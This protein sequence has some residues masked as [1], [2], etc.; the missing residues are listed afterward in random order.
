MFLT[1]AKSSKDET[2]FPTYYDAKKARISQE[3]YVN[4]FPF[5]LPANQCQLSGPGGQIGWHWL[6]GNSKAQ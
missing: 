3:T 4:V 6:D 1:Q 2:F 5:K